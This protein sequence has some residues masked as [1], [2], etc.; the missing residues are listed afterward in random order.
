MLGEPVP[1]PSPPR[2]IRVFISSTFRDMQAERDEL[3]KRVFPQLR[4]L[5]ERRGVTWG[6]IDLR[7]GV[8]D[9]Q[10][11]EGGVLPVCLAEIHRC[12]PYFIGLLGDRYGWVPDEVPPRYAGR[13]RG[14]L[15]CAAT[16][17]PSWRSACFTTRRPPNTPSSIF[18][19]LL[20][21]ILYRCS[22]SPTPE[23]IQVLGVEESARRA[24]ERKDK[25]ASLK[26][27]N[28][29]SHGERFGRREWWVQA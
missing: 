8:T 16:R 27:R 5:C 7:W 22:G 25:L 24:Q 9:E 14:W 29:N 11:A 13:S 18:A 10:R 3:A 17:S 4:K 2:V 21:S 1:I 23:E 28:R 15:N 19:I 12:R 6:E 26:G 20:T